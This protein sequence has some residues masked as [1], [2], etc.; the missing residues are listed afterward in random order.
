MKQTI[1]KLQ[2]E[3]TSKDATIEQLR[4]QISDLQRENVRL[5]GQK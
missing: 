1:A 2:E 4:K 5:K 3:V